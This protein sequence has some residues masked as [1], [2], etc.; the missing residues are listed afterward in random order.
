[1]SRSKKPIGFDR[2]IELEW[3]DATAEWAAEGLPP[4]EIRGRLD[5]FLAE[6]VAGDGPHSA[7]G[8]T[9]TVLLHIWVLVPDA[10]VPLRDRGLALLRGLPASARLPLHWGMSVATYPFFREVAATTGRLLNVQGNAPMAQVMRRMIESWGQRS[11]LSRAVA[12]VL[13]S[14][15]DWGALLETHDRGVFVSAPKA[16]TDGYEGVGVWLAEACL[17]GAESAMVQFRQLIA[18]PAL[19]PFSVGL[20]SRDLRRSPSLEVIRQGLSEDYV[21]LSGSAFRA[22]C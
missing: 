19:F 15:V 21:R 9:K 7:K 6:H 3:L 11:T 16:S 10:L 22:D 4:D 5:S 12:R 2:K 13:R 20:T 8:K 17:S 18:N 1:M 14:F